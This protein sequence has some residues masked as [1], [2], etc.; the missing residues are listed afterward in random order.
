MSLPFKYT[1]I[2]TFN[3]VQS[4]YKLNHSYIPI[5]GKKNDEKENDFKGQKD[6][7]VNLHPL[8]CSCQDGFKQ[9][10]R[11]LGKCLGQNR[12]RQ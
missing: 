10:I 6:T 12:A 7:F 9:V 1:D 3:L 5:Q 2:I 4:L 8:R 11:E